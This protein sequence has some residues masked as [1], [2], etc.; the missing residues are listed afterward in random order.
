[1]KRLLILTIPLIIG[2]QL[3]A[4]SPQDTLSLEECYD[5]LYTENPLTDKIQTNRQITDLNKRIAQSGWYPDV[6]LNASA[7]YQSEV[8][9]FPFESPGFEVPNFSKDHYNL[10]FNVTQPIFDGGRTR[11]SKQLEDDSGDVTEAT[12]ESDLLS[13]KEQVDRIYFGI[14]VLQKQ[15]E[16]VDL[17]VSDM[18]EQLELVTSQVENGVLLPGNEAALRA[19]ILNREQQLTKLHRDIDA[20]HEALS[21]ILG[22]E[23][24][25]IPILKLPEK[26]NWREPEPMATRPETD[27]LD[28][29]MN[30]FESQEELAISSKLPQVSLFA[31]PSYGRPGFNIFE[32][33]L[34]F[35]WIVG[36]QAR[37]SLK[38]AR[39]ASVKTDILRLRQRNIADDRILFERQ[40]N[41]AMRRLNQEIM[42]LEEQIE[43]DR[44]IVELRKQVADEKKSLVEEGSA[45][46]TEYITELNESIRAQRQLEL[47]K[48]QRIQAISNYETEQGWT[49]N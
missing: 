10:S 48:I 39:N 36:I 13:L 12:L 3:F 35:N 7:S 15:K 24:P 22:G 14:L 40:Q 1:M 41:T 4:Q 11:T 32:D 47:R 9:E 49:W 18:K 37:W 19:E 6:E 20:G 28:A 26:E 42:G 46:V 25:D 34:Q 5:I 30:L 21:V 45:T 16:I 38:T 31:S 33:D 2:S 27:L 44:E 23:I 43:R 17:A 8:V 29:R